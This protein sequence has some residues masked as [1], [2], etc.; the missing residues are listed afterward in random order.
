MRRLPILL[1][2]LVACKKKEE[3][4]PEPMPTG[5]PARGHS[6][7]KIKDEGQEPDG[8][9][10][11]TGTGRFEKLGNAG[12]SNDDNGKAANAKPDARTEPGPPGQ[13]KARVHG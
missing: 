9:G 8:S 7:T 2:L 11:A 13:R 1:L 6:V 5:E 12:E 10:G 4:A 3:P